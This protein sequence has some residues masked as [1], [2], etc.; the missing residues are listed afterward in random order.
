LWVVWRLTRHRG[1]RNG[2]SEL[3]PNSRPS[4]IGRVEALWSCDER[5]LSQPTS[6]LPEQI[7]FTMPRVWVDRMDHTRRFMKRE[8]SRAPQNLPAAPRACS[9]ALHSCDA[10]AVADHRRDDARSELCD[11]GPRGRR[12]CH[13]SAI[14]S[15]RR[16]SAGGRRGASGVGARLGSAWKSPVLRGSSGV[17]VY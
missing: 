3:T 2:A 1:R 7:E 17:P 16:G 6:K 13:A 14:Y 4:R 15:H 11:E 9:N 5:N 8:R 12:C 10:E